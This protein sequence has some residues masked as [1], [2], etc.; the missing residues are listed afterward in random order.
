MQVIGLGKITVATAGT[1]VAFSVTAVKVHKVIV[2]FDPADTSA[3]VYV[4]D[5]AGTIIASL[6]TGNPPLVIG[7]GDGGNELDISTL[8]ADTGTNSKGPYVG[9]ELR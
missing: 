4:K 2:T 9:Y 3:T 6:V 8:F 7:G 1:K 5:A